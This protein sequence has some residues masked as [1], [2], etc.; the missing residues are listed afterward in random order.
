MAKVAFAALLLLTACYAPAVL[1][2]VG[3]FAYSAGSEISRAVRPPAR[4]APIPK[5]SGRVNHVVY[6][7]DPR[8]PCW[9][10][11]FKEWAAVHREVCAP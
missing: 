7:D 11:D 9:C 5:R 6:A 4:I 1:V 10:S 2:E 3:A 8:V